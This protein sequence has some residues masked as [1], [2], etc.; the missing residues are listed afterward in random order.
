MEEL[1][2]HAPQLLCVLGNQLSCTSLL[3]AQLLGMVEAISMLL[4]PILNVISLR[5][6]EPNTNKK[7]QALKVKHSSDFTELGT[8]HSVEEDRVISTMKEKRKER[9]DQSVNR[10]TK[11]TSKKQEKREQGGKGFQ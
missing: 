10:K 3:L 6:L 5:L 2:A 4:A 1:G 9:I 7:V 11:S 8:N